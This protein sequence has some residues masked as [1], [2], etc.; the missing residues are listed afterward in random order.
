MQ[1]DN[2]P[3]LAGFASESFRAC[4]NSLYVIQ[5]AQFLIQIQGT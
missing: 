5:T 1:G 2:T 4:G 3:R